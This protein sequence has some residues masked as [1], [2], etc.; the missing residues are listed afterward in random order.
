MRE[1]GGGEKGREK[2]KREREEKERRR[3][4]EKWGGREGGRRGERD[5]L[6][7]YPVFLSFIGNRAQ[8]G[9]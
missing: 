5:M 8:A 2:R 6:W 7:L 4:T 9:S 1:R 3:G